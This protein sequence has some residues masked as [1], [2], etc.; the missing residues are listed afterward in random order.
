MALPAALI[1]DDPGALRL[2]N[3]LRGV[4]GLILAAGATFAAAQFTAQSSS[5]VFL[6]TMTG[7]LL[8][9]AGRGPDQGARIRASGAAVAGALIGVGIYYLADSTAFPQVLVAPLL[10]G[11][12]TLAAAAGP[13]AGAAGLGAAWLHIFAATFAVP[14]ESLE[15]HLLAVTLGGGAMAATRF[16][17]WPEN[18]PND[19]R[20]LFRA[21]CLALAA[22]LKNGTRSSPERLEVFQTLQRRRAAVL[23]ALSHP[24]GVP[25]ELVRALDDA[26][27]ATER[28]AFAPQAGNPARRRRLASALR[29]GT[30]ESLEP[31]DLKEALERARKH[32]DEPPGQPED[33]SGAPPRR[34]QEFLDR[35]ARMTVAAALAASLGW[36]ISEDRW[37]WAVL[38]ALMLFIGAESSSHLMAK[39]LRSMLGVAGGIVIGA[40]I[41]WLISGHPVLEVVV[42]LASMTLALYF[43]PVRYAVAT[44]F[45]TVFIALSFSLSGQQVTPI[46]ELRLAE[47]AVGLVAGAVATFAVPTAS[48]RSA[49]ARHVEQLREQLLAAWRSPGRNHSRD[50]YAALLSAAT[51]ALPL[52]RNRADVH[53][54]LAASARLVHLTDLIDL[55]PPGE[56]GLLQPRLDALADHIEGKEANPRDFPA[57][58]E[59]L[60]TIMRSLETATK[61]PALAGALAK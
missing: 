33:L 20:A 47:V 5:G 54:A 18:R 8:L 16:L 1:I 37:G 49:L 28:L 29:E 38:T 6:G 46:L 25:V 4:L 17:L 23:S 15:W 10:V 13:L 61:D 56:R 26:V 2:R 21:F 55:L 14:A 3:A 39:A 40:G 11:V 60:G 59:R 52:L 12:A 24:E 22:T 50:A 42:M 44:G 30:V 41:A 43:M 51:P 53:R 36:L 48:F 7:Q 35:V 45:L 57:L 32:L 58:P 19:R 34:Q 9:L 27:L 31:G